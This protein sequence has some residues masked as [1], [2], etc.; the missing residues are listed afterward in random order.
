METL[1]NIFS[2]LRTRVFLINLG[3]ATG[4]IILL[5][6]SIHIWL[7]SYTNHGNTTTVPDFKGLKPDQLAD[8][9]SDKD[10]KFKIIDSIYNPKLPKGVVVDQEP[11]SNFT[12]KQGRTVYLTLNTYNPPKIKLPNLVDVPMRQAQ[13]IL[14]SY[15]LKVGQLIY[16]PN[17]N[18][19][20]TIE[21]RSHGVKL[22]PGAPMAK[23]SVIDIVLGDGVGETNVG[24]PN[25]LGLSYQE[26]IFAIKGSGLEL[27]NIVFDETVHD[28]IAA[29]VYIQIPE[30]KSDEKL[31]QG[32][33]IDLYLTQ[34]QDKLKAIEG[35]E[36]K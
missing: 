36:K 26:A 27:G 9:T 35:D 4:L 23:G 28:S 17:L 8:F 25:V 2:F 34:S 29:R 32:T 20:I 6:S 31:T 33:P 16:E 10:V 15:G 30:P 18:K 13:A 22:S 19:N 5:L 11:A 1:R 21:L 14:Q 7:S 24:V 12:V 3:I